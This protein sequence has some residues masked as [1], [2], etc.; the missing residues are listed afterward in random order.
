MRSKSPL[1][2]PQNYKITTNLLT[3][4]QKH[5][6]S[7]L[8]TGQNNSNSPQTDFRLKKREFQLSTPN[9][10]LDKQ[11]LIST[12]NNYYH[13]NSIQRIQT[14]ESPAKILFKTGYEQQQEIKKLTQENQNLK[15][16]VR[17]QEDQLKQFFELENILEQ[18]KQLQEKIEKLEQE[19]YI[20]RQAQEQVNKSKD[21]Q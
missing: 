19:N 5:H 6:V 13:P 1:V 8:S 7:Q 16:L 17:K 3:P 12:A 20:L 2:S 10:V 11:K 9:Q 14:S 18:N 21:D 15:E 4:T